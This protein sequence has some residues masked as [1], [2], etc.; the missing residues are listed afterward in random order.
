M[1][2]DASRKKINIGTSSDYCPTQHYL[3]DRIC[4]DKVALI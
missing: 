3:V 2:C 4:G 1:G